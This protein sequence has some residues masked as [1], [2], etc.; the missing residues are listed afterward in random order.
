M[1]TIT[2]YQNKN[3]NEFNV[4]FNSKLLGVIKSENEKELLQK[5]KMIYDY[6][7]LKEPESIILVYYRYYTTHE[8]R[9]SIYDLDNLNVDLLTRDF[10]DDYQKSHCSVD[11][12]DNTYIRGM[13]KE[14]TLNT[15]YFPQT[16]YK[17]DDGTMSFSD[18]YII[19]ELSFDMFACRY[20]A[21][22]VNHQITN[23]TKLIIDNHFDNDIVRHNILKYTKI[24]DFT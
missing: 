7:A 13:L 1:N 16:G 23:Q 24:T 18:G 10:S 19:N 22:V 12:D 5:A 6:L 15:Y 17:K 8:H 21:K 14:A 2:I 20:I 11:V 4:Y 3:Q 9:F